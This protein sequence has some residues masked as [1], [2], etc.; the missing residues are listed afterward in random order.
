MNYSKET[1][2]T[3]LNRLAKSIETIANR[4]VPAIPPANNSISGNAVQ[5][6]KITQ[7]R[8]TGITDLAA[9]MVL[10][11]DGDGITVDQ[12]STDRIATESLTVT[13]DLDVQGTLSAQ[14]LRVQNLQSDRRMEGSLDFTGPDLN[15]IGLQWRTR[16]DQTKQFVWSDE[17]FYSSNSINLARRQAFKIDNVEV[18]SADSLGSNVRSSN[19]VQVGTLQNLNTIGDLMIDEFIVYNSDDMRLGIGTDAPNAQ[20]S[21]VGER[22]EFII[23]PQPENVKVGTY[24]TSHL[25]IITDNKTRIHVKDTGDINIK[26]KLGI[27]VEYPTADLDVAGPIRVQS[28][29]IGFGVSQPDIGDY[30]QGDVVHNSNPQP[31]GWAGWICVEGGS[32]GTWKKFGRIEE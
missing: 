23:D 13:G 9:R 19:L 1:I 17:Q 6:G 7:F 30:N 3:G 22:D 26:T 21:V 10:L 20:V 27:G 14:D 31:G 16:D 29:K 24:S 8:S 25:K 5:G 2:H 18:L 4:D 32:P 15:M 28:N 12:V 11:V